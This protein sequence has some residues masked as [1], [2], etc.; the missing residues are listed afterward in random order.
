MS[1]YDY[2]G[3]V[4]LQYGSGVARILP[5]GSACGLLAEPGGT[6]QLDRMPDDGLWRPVKPAKR[7]EKDTATTRGAQ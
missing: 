7:A 5:D 3:A 2:L 4:P 1:E 6:Y